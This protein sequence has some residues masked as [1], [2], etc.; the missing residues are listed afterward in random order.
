MRRLV[1]SAVLLA[2]ACAP[3]GSAATPPTPV[4]YPYSTSTAFP[5][6]DHM[7]GA[8]VSAETPAPSP[9][10]STYTIKAG[11]TLSQIAERARISVDAL[12]L[13]N[14]GLDPN[15][16]RVGATLNVPGSAGSAALSTPT[17][18]PVDILDVDCRPMATG[19]SWC[20][21]L[22]HNDSSDLLENVTGIVS[23]QDANAQ[24]LASQ[25]VALLLDVLP[26]GASMPLAVPFQGPLPL[27]IRPQVRILTA[28]RVPSNTPRYLPAVT[29]NTL[30]QVSWSGRAADVSGEVLL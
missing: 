3:L 9:T 27:D 12:I 23:I 18:V 8:V 19:A 15:A 26:P 22:I 29:H 6:P 30:T 28:M 5:T 25:D 13:A 2:A 17:P 4:L 20:F 1:V 11:D 7:T 21:A 10:P 24:V 16:L 14:P